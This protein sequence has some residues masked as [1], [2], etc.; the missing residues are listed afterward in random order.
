[1]K[2]E[3]EQNKIMVIDSNNKNLTNRNPIS[4]LSLKPYWDKEYI[5]EHIETIT[6]AKD[7]MLIKF[8]WMT[9]V[10][11]TE[12]I[13]IKR[14]D[15]D[16]KNYLIKIR[17]LKSRKY[18]ERMIPMH[19]SLKNI[20]ELFV[21]ALRQDDKVFPFTRQRGWQITQQYLQG[22]PH[23]L[24]HSFAV[25]W[26][27]NEGNLNTLHLILGHSKIQ[28]TLEYTKLVPTDIGKELM[29]ISFD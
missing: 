5:N 27:R 21:A 14:S 6:D 17:W 22:N 16:F 11:I 20:L 12:A 10:R 3:R 7:K 24:R 29:K 13:N 8:L 23:K 18:S 28:T 15:I 26:L 19:P 4:K 25:N 1:M 9:G 2:Q